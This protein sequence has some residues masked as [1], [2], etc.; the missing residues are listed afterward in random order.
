MK[1]LLKTLLAFFVSVSGIAAIYIGFKLLKMRGVLGIFASFIFPGC[2]F[3]ILAGLVSIILPFFAFKKT[4]ILSLIAL[5]EGVA[6]IFIM[7]DEVTVFHR[8]TSTETI[9][10]IIG[11]YL[12]IT[13]VVLLFLIP[14]SSSKTQ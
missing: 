9:A 11:T 6:I 8:L 5:Q 3:F 13:S 14:S 7:A 2:V 12:I 1:R 10:A 4:H